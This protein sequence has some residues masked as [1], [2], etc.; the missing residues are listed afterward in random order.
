MY[1]GI[2]WFYKNSIICDNLYKHDLLPFLSCKAGI[3]NIPGNRF[4]TNGKIKE[5]LKLNKESLIKCIW[6]F[7]YIQQKQ[8]I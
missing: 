2:C 3:L 1:I 7:W 5:I 6:V 8:D 4:I